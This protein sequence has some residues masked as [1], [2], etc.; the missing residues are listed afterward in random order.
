MKTSAGTHV[1]LHLE[2]DGY[3]LEILM[4]TQYILMYIHRLL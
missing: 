2:I 3:V 4:D 1:E